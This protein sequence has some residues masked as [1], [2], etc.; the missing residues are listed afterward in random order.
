MEGAKKTL[1][2]PSWLR[3]DGDDEDEGQRTSTTARDI[4]ADEVDSKRGTT[5]VAVVPIQSGT[6]LASPPL[7]MTDAS[8]RDEV[9]QELRLRREEEQSKQSRSEMKMLSND[10]SSG[11]RSCGGGARAMMRQL[12]E[13][14]RIEKRASVQRSNSRSPSSAVEEQ[15]RE[16]RRP[17]G[18]VKETVVRPFT[19]PR[20]LSE[21][22]LSPPSMNGKGGTSST[23]RTP[24][25]LQQQILPSQQNQQRKKNSSP[26][27]DE[28]ARPNRHPS[29]S[30]LIRRELALG[31]PVHSNLA[32]ARTSWPA[33]PPTRTPSPGLASPT[34]LEDIAEVPSASVTELASGGGPTPRRANTIGHASQMEHSRRA[35]A[36][37]GAGSLNRS[38]S[39]S[40]K[41]TALSNQRGNGSG[42]GL[43][44]SNHAHSSEGRLGQAKHK[45]RSSLKDLVARIKS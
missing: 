37:N 20:R 32:G 34:T 22:T 2:L 11:L 15:S 36:A 19:S 28:A 41:Q 14:E 9:N 10:S 8:L 45:A 18:A 43:N 38:S 21:H 16:E 6:A 3:S 31:I 42:L 17:M 39:L 35:G 26:S 1:K 25:P 12:E 5:R 4:R 29:P 44:L 24:S 13:A 30:L 23:P 40:S 27:K 7:E 33:H